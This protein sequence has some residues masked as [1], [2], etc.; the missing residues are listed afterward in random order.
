MMG[1]ELDTYMYIKNESKIKLIFSATWI[2]VIEIQLIVFT[3]MVM[4]FEV[5]LI[6]QVMLG[7][8]LVVSACAVI[9][10]KTHL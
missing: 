10:C 7:L 1:C 9:A 5:Q 8:T 3:I 2:G 6:C 4:Y